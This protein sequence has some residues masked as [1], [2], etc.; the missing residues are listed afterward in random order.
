MVVVVKV[1]ETPVKRLCNTHNIITVNG[2]FPGP[3]VFAREGD[4]VVVRVVN[5]VPYNMSIHW[6][7]RAR[8][9]PAATLPV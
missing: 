3:T 5:H 8:R 7:V 1:Q 2:Q 6:Y 4:L 9:M